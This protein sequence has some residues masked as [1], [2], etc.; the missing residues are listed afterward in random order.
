MFAGGPKIIVTPLNDLGACAVCPPGSASAWNR[1]C[2][3]GR[4]LLSTHVGVHVVL[5]GYW[6][7]GLA[8]CDLWQLSDVVMCTSS[9][10]HMCSISLDRYTAIR[11]PCGLLLQST[12]VAWSSPYTAIG[13]PCGLLL[14]STHV[15]WS[16]PYTAIRDPCGL[17][18]QSTHVAWSHLP[19]RLSETRAAYCYIVH[20]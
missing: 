19:T 1:H 2:R 20:T 11:D 9:I 8:M 3:P 15:A 6:P 14:Q 12:H 10:M 7:F 13:D 16:S 4:S 5:S 17:L 18:L